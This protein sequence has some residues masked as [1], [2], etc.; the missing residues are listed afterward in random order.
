MN[1]NEAQME[2]NAQRKERIRNRYKGID[3]SEI[4]L[5]PAIVQEDFYHDTTQ[6]RVAVYARVST[7]DPNQTSSYELQKNHYERLVTKHENWDLIDIY[8][9]E[10]I[11]GTSLQH[12]DAFIKMIDDCKAGKID[13]IVTKS[14]SRFARN[15]LDSIGTVRELKRLDPPVGVFFETENI[16]TLNQDSEMSLSFIS[17]MAQ[18]ESHTKSEIMNSSIEMRFRMGIFLKPALLGYTVD[19]DGNLVINPEEAKIVRLIFFL[20]LYGYKTQQIAETLT[21]LNVPTKTGKSVWSAGTINEILRNERHCG[22]ILARKTYTEDYLTHKSKK[23]RQNRNQYRKRDDHEAIISR[24]DFIAVQHMMANSRFRNRGVLPELDVISSGGLSGFVVINPRWAGFSVEDYIKACKSVDTFERIN[25]FEAQEGDFDLRGFEVARQQFFNTKNNIAVS[26]TKAGLSFSRAAIKKLPTEYVELL[27]HPIEKLLVIRPAKMEDKNSV[28]WAK[29]LGE[30]YISKS[31]TTSAFLP[32]LY[33]GNGWD[34]QMR[35]KVS[36]IR[37]QNGDKVILIFDLNDTEIY[38]PTR[39]V[40]PEIENGLDETSRD[41]NSLKAYPTDWDGDFGDG[42]YEQ[43][44]RSSFDGEITDETTGFNLH[45][46]LNITPEAELEEGIEALMAELR[47]KHKQDQG[48]QL[49]I[50]DAEEEST[51]GDAE[52]TE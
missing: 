15:I 29:K 28:R 35:Y 50:T 51:D 39:I 20:Y 44:I 31:F 11:S 43:M 25:R 7:D 17:T 36:G 38:I 4:D 32:K 10:G 24:D 46:E 37:R 47:E 16:Y 26:I 22:D 21:N 40:D 23:N 42:Y 13:M 14:V 5:I 49:E 18:E 8:A 34:I 33:E 12:R 2:T 52:D 41:R 27:W 19:K 45:P 3:P 48:E 1:E 30:N 9:D 6:K